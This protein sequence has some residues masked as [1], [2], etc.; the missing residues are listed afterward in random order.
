MPGVL[1]SYALGFGDG[2]FIHGALYLNLLG[3]EVTH[4]CI[5]LH[6]EDLQFIFD[7]VPLGALFIIT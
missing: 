3:K 1:G 7:T 5:Q 4:G 2:Y 6:P